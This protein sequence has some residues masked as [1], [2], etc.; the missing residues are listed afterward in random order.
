MFPVST[1][2]EKGKLGEIT[3]DN[4]YIYIKTQEGWK[5]AGLETF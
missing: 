2:D 4:D 5:R 1:N 3:R